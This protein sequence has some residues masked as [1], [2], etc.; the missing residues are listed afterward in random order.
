MID[1]PIKPLSVNS[2]WKGKRYK[3]NDYKVY[4]NFCLILLPALKMPPA[5]YELTI[6]FSF[7]SSASD[8][9][10]PLKCFI[11]ILQRKYL[12]NDKD[13]YKL[14]VTKKIV[15]KNQEK[16]SFKIETLK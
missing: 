9:D 6:E 13:I 14:I 1:I 15:P 12:I 2:A 10:N 5:P 4:E 8:L 3:T 7:S 11:D 16:I